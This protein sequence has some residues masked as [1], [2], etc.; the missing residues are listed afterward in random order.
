MLNKFKTK[1]TGRQVLDIVTVAIM[2]VALVLLFV[3]IYYYVRPVKTADI[4]VPVATDKA[5]Y[6]PGQ[7]I[8][9]IFFGEIYYDGEVRILR[10]VFCKDYHGVIKPTAESAAGNFFSTQSKPHKLEGTSVKIGTLPSDVPIGANCVLQFTNVYTINTPFGTRQI[11]Y[12]YYTQN[13]AIT[14][15]ERREQLDNEANNDQANARTAP[16]STW[17]ADAGD[18]TNTTNNY[19]T[20]VNEAPDNPATPSEPV[21]PPDD[22]GILQRIVDFVF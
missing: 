4:K 15:K 1:T 13:F 8:G 6:Y 22:R 11:E 9:G 12:Q 19:N 16:Q 21:T 7:E 17:P 20:T 10:E 18:T 3:L 5:S 2:A 14:S